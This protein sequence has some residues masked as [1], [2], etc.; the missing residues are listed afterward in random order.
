ME[1]G[2]EMKGE[3]EEEEGIGVVGDGPV[4]VDDRAPELLVEEAAALTVELGSRTT[5]SSLTR[6]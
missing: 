6:A 2:A 1:S 5:P 4:D 3:V